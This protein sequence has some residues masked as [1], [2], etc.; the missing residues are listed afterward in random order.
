MAPESKPTIRCEDFGEKMLLCSKTQKENILNVRS[1]WHELHFLKD[2]D[3]APP[4]TILPFILEAD[5]F[6]DAMIW[7]AGTNPALGLPVWSFFDRPNEKSEGGKLPERFRSRLSEIFGCRFL[8]TALL[9]GMVMDKPPS[10][11]NLAG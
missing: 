9:D 3:Y 4:P 8:E 7:I 5:N 10:Y 6:E 1:E 11:V 2:R